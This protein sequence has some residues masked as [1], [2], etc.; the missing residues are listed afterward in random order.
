MLMALATKTRQPT[1]IHHRKRTGSHHRK[2]AKHY[3][4]TYWPYLPLLGIVGFGFLL[5][6]LWWQPPQGSVLAY[7]TNTSAG[8]LLQATNTQRVAAGEPSL[9]ANAQLTSAAQ[10]K[11]NDMAARDYWSHSTPDGHEPWWFVT[12]AGYQYQSTGENL[13]YGFD[14]SQATING[15][16]NSSGHRANILNADYQDVGFGIVNVEHY[17][18]TEPQTIVVALYG[19]PLNAAAAIATAQPPAPAASKVAV[20]AVTT[21]SQPPAAASAPVASPA[22]TA[23]SQPSQTAVLG[24]ETPA[25]AHNSQ[26]LATSQPV[27]RLQVLHQISPALLTVIIGLAI[28]GAFVFVARHTYAA[29]RSLIKGEEFFVRHWQLDVVIVAAVVVVAVLSRTAGFIQ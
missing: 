13:A 4:K 20:A 22:A 6:S 27:S 23:V 17:Q 10:A 11:A 24:S 28:A 21:H 26:V 3:G 18:G 16:M 2:Q 7:A 5:N 25:D 1:A 14:N 29:H 12:N 15:W 9:T 8:G 19:K